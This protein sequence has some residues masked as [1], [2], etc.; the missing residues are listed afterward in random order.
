MLT[1]QSFP[2]FLI[3]WESLY[4][5]L[6]SQICLCV[7]WLL[8]APPFPIR[9]HTYQA[10]YGKIVLECKEPWPLGFYLLLSYIGLLAFVCLLL[11]FLGRKLPDTFNEAKFI[12][13]SMLIFWAVWIS[14]IPAYVSSPGKFS[15][16]VEI[17]A[18][19]ASSF[20]LLMCIFVPKCYI[21]L[22]HPE[23]NIRKGITGKYN[24]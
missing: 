10:S 8:G 16:A 15:V 5:S 21:I 1:W 23:R 4:C 6:F 3:F 17:F 12:T 22:L 20:G 14:F 24:R 18:I 2:V 9:N 7:G 11:A 19:L 13:F